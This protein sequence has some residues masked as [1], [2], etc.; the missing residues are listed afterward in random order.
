MSVREVLP[1]AEEV[2]VVCDEECASAD[3]QGEEVV[4]VGVA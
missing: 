4:V 2:V 1:Q 3:G